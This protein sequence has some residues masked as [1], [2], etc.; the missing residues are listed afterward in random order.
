MS[1]VTV[2]YK[3]SRSA[4]FLLVTQWSKLVLG[5]SLMNDLTEKVLI[6]IITGSALNFYLLKMHIA[7]LDEYCLSKLVHLI[8]SAKTFPCQME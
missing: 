7:T 6:K 8:A 5:W 1:E 3:R 4:F 2:S